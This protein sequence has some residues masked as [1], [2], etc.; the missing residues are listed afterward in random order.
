V[1][2]RHFLVRP[3]LLQFLE[4]VENLGVESLSLSEVLSV[5]V[6]LTDR[7]LL[8]V[9]IVNDCSLPLLRA[10]SCYIAFASSAGSGPGSHAL[11]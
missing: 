6:R 5:S 4:H 7:V 1:L 9:E 2:I 3:N 8:R 10:A 11:A